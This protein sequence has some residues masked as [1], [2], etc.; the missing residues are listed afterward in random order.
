[1]P[2]KLTTSLSARQVC[3][4]DPW[5]LIYVDHDGPPHPGDLAVLITAD[6]YEFLGVVVDLAPDKA[7]GVAL[8]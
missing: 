8:K 3:D 7:V 6:G 5:D 4:G 2:V 1:M